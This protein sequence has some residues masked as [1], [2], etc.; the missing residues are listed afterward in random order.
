MAQWVSKY[1]YTVFLY[2][3]IT[4]YPDQSVRVIF[5]LNPKGDNSIVCH[6]V[7]T[8]AVNVTTKRAI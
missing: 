8:Q 5:C 6:T 2:G 3:R 1:D 7:P 4:F